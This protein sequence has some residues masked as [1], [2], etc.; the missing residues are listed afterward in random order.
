MV[1]RPAHDRLACEFVRADEALRYPLA[2]GQRLGGVERLASM[3]FGGDSRVGC[4]A[5][6]SGLDDD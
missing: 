6:L 1:P 2:G 5:G 3:G 4:E